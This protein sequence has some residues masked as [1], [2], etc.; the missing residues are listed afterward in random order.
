MKTATFTARIAKLLKRHAGIAV[1]S[2]A[3]FYEPSKIVGKKNE[4]TKTPFPLT[5]IPADWSS[6]SKSDEEKNPRKDGSLA[7]FWFVMQNEQ[8]EQI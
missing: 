8:F 6:K 5:G 7:L 3:K 4:E 2:K 1:I